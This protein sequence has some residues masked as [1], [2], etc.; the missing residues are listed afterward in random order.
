MIL[1]AGW[2]VVSIA[3]ALAIMFPVYRVIDGNISDQPTFVRRPIW[4]PPPLLKS[5]LDQQTS[6]KLE[7]S[8]RQENQQNQSISDSKV[9]SQKAK[10]IF[11]GSK[12]RS[13]HRNRNW[14]GTTAMFL[15]IGYGVLAIYKWQNRG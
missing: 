11:V 10:P 6:D 3:V 12:G 9:R 2:M 4:D 5:E 8:V 1:F 15:V 14:L 13:S 7:G